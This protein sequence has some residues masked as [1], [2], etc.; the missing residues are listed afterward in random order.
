LYKTTTINKISQD[1][2]CNILDEI[3]DRERRTKWKQQEEGFIGI[4]SGRV[5]Q[6]LL[7][8]DM[9]RIKEER[10]K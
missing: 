5:K 1:D 10:A 6:P 4:V 7:M 9:A 3:F 2:F 8:S